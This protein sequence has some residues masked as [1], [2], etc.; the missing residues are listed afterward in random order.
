MLAHSVK[1]LL[2]MPTSCN[3][4]RLCSVSTAGE[5]D[6]LGDG[7][8]HLVRRQLFLSGVRF[9][10]NVDP[11]RLKENARNR[12]INLDVDKM[13]SYEGLVVALL[14]GVVTG[15]SVSGL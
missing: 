1:Q 3:A 4:M 10:K 6:D 12:D 11:E 2:L 15:T 13:V 14:A 5:K 7:E 9:L 8:M